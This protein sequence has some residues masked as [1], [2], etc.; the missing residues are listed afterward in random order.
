MTFA[1]I[2]EMLENAVILA[3]GLGTSERT[4]AVRVLSQTFLV[5]PLCL[6]VLAKILLSAGVNLYFF[7]NSNFY[8][9]TL[10]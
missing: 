8:I 9:Y 10:S 5:A 4:L 2:L 7:P 1:G 3:T 6:H